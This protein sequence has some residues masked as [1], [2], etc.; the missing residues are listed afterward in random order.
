MKS[1]A[2]R[3]TCE[4]RTGEPAHLRV[5]R[6]EPGATLEGGLVAAIH[7]MQLAGGTKPLDAL[8]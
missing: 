4:T 7:R 2:L 3:R 6:F 1:A 8:S 5:Y